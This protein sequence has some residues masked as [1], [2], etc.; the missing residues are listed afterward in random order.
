M[1]NTLDK[2]PMLLFVLLL[3]LLSIYATIAQAPD[4]GSEKSKIGSNNE[5]LPNPFTVV[6]NSISGNSNGSGHRLAGIYIP[7]KRQPRS[8]W[9]PW[10]LWRLR[11]W[12]HLKTYQQY[13]R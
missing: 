7:R 12:R 6:S 2:T 3:V 13:K 11:L 9:K 10:E 8:P 4:T 5:T 1:L